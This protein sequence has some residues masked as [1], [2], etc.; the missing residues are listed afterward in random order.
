MKY[1]PFLKDQVEYHSIIQSVV[2]HNDKIKI[3]NNVKTDKS[4]DTQNYLLQQW[5]NVNNSLTS[6]SSDVNTQ[7]IDNFTQDKLDI[8]AAIKSD[9]NISEQSSMS[10]ADIIVSLANETEKLNLEIQTYTVE[11]DSCQQELQKLLNDINNEDNLYKK[12]N[13]KFELIAKSRTLLDNFEENLLKLQNKAENSTKK[14]VHLS[15]QWE[16]HKTGYLE[17]YQA[18]KLKA[19]SRS[20]CNLKLF[21]YA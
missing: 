21:E 6:I 9:I 13:D 10:D 18:A 7:V 11:I 12:A 16:E 1:L 20:V 2:A 5:S 17:Q 14:L 3:A 19:N 4:K 8:K 15:S